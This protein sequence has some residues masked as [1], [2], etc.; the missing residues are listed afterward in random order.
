MGDRGGKRTA[1]R[2]PAS[3]LRP[4]RRHPR[5]HADAVEAG[6]VPTTRRISHEAAVLRPG[7]AE[8]SDRPQCPTCVCEE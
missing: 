3:G 4:R 1:A 5:A 7:Y 6:A 8:S 2:S